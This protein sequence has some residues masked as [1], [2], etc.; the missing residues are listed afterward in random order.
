MIQNLRN[1]YARN[2]ILRGRMGRALT[3]PKGASIMMGNASVCL[4]TT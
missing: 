3:V 4:T 2:S 1:V